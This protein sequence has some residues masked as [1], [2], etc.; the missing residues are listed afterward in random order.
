M[1]SVTCRWLY[2]MYQNLLVMALISVYDN[3]MMRYDK[4]NICL[5]VIRYRCTVYEMFLGCQELYIFTSIT[6]CMSSRSRSYLPYFFCIFFLRSFFSPIEKRYRVIN[7]ICMIRWQSYTQ[8]TEHKESSS[9]GMNT[10]NDFVCDRSLL[11]ENAFTLLSIMWHYASE[12]KRSSLLI[13]HRIKYCN[14]HNLFVGKK[15]ISFVPYGF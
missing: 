5:F 2:Y 3:I 9:F 6:N 1:F 12:A 15:T 7:M 14:L 4:E 8:E 13:G 10:W 11:N